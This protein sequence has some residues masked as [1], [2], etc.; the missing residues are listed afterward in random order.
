MERA[1]SLIS[2][3][4]LLLVSEINIFIILDTAELFR[5]FLNDTEKCIRLASKDSDIVNQISKEDLILDE[6]N[7]QNSILNQVLAGMNPSFDRK[8]FII[9]EHPLQEKFEQLFFNENFHFKPEID[10]LFSNL[11][12]PQIFTDQRL[13]LLQNMLDFFNLKDSSSVSIFS[14]IFD[15]AV[16]SYG[17]SLNQDFFW[18]KVECCFRGNANRVN[19]NQ[20][21]ASKEFLPPHDGNDSIKE[22]IAK[23]ERLTNAAHELTTSAFLYSPFDILAVIHRVL[24]E[25]RTFACE[26]SKSD[27]ALAF[28]T[29]FGLFIMTLISSDLPNQEQVFKFALDFTPLEGLSASLEYARATVSAALMLCNSIMEKLNT[30]K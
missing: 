25:I 1:K 16:F 5:F 11:Q 2:A 3:L 7:S 15:R 18:S 10:G 24:G 20:V 30:N 8:S 26:V 9:S 13:D 14:F 12:N 4:H 17:I 19:I 23:S 27:D 6:T 29:I 22:I 21:G 28:D